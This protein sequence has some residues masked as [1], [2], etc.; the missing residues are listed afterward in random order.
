[1]EGGLAVRRKLR[2]EDQLWRMVEGSCLLLEDLDPGLLL[3]RGRSQ[4]KEKRGDEQD[5]KI[6]KSCI[7]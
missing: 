4:G 5:L 1:M 6:N 2:R 7:T 3:V